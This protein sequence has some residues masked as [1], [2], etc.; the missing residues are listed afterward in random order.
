MFTGHAPNQNVFTPIF[1]NDHSTGK[2]ISSGGA[3]NGIV[4]LIAAGHVRSQMTKS[5][6]WF[7][8]IG[9]I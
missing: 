6:R 2:I 3:E 9:H 1:S 7:I 4:F 8:F 5:E